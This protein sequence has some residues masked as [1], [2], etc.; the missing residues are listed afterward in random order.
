MRWAQGQDRANEMAEAL[1]RA[2]FTD[3]QDINDLETL[4][5]LAAQIGMDRNIVKDLYD[6][7]ADEDAVLGEIASI[8]RAGI[9]SVPSYIYQGQYLV[10]G[11]QPA[12]AHLNMIETLSSGANTP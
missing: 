6:K 1:F 9:R 4:Q 12:K 5:T 10:Q 2:F 11:A 7:D 8:S 3:H